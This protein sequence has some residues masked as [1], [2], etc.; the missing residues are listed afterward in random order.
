M[1]PSTLQ[2]PN[3]ELSDLGPRTIAEDAPQE[4]RRVALSKV[5]GIFKG[6]DDAPQ[7][8]LAF[9]LEMRTE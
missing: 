1:H 7:D 3:D 6:R 8:G 2:V 4:R 9:Q 5:F